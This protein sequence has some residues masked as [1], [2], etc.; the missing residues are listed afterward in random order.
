MTEPRH[1]VWFSC[2]AASACVAKLAPRDAIVVYCDTMVSEH[3]DNQRFFNDVQQWI[4]KP[5]FR[6]RSKQY[7]DVDDVFDRTRYMSGVKGARCT[8]EMKKVPRFEFQQPDD[9]HYFGLT[10]D[11]Q[12]RIRN[13]VANNPDLNLEWVLDDRMIIKDDCYAMVE[14]A[15][16]RLPTMYTLGFNNNNCLGCVKATSAKYWAKVR[17]LF[18]EVFARR[19]A[20]SRELGVKL[21]R[22][23]DVRIFL[24]ELPLIIDGDEP[25][26][27]DIECGP[28]CLQEAA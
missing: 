23:K 5:I 27:E 25:E 17:R 3:P 13:F 4:R 26:E 18:P 14:A 19:A 12:R 24:D 8:V 16:I 15:G 11:E 10:F 6:I 22:Y 7:I 9:I 28:V 21:A 20:Q 2:G 1:I